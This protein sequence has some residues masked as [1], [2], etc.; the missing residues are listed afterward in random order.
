MNTLKIFTVT[1]KASIQEDTWLPHTLTLLTFL[2]GK[3]KLHKDE[4]H[5]FD[6]NRN[7]FLSLA[8]KS[9]FEILEYRKSIIAPTDYASCRKISMNPRLSHRCFFYFNWAF[10][11]QI[12]FAR[13]SPNQ[14]NL[15]NFSD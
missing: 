8:S 13:K 6:F 3:L 10:L 15:K 9:R 7:A 2:S 1:M 14:K 11:N 5:A 4:F 12:F